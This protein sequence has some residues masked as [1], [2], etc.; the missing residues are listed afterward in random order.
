VEKKVNLSAN[1]SAGSMKS[2]LIGFIGGSS[3][4]GQNAR[5][6]LCHKKIGKSIAISSAM[7][8]FPPTSA[9]NDRR[10]DWS[11]EVRYGY[12]TT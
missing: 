5:L 1:T 7:A 4:G 2:P 8:T 12:S 9:T 10:E 6:R 11:V 3:G